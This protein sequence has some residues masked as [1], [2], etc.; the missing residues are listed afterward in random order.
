MTL[1]ELKEFAEEQAEDTVWAICSWL[2]EMGL[3][4]DVGDAQFM[5]ALGV[6]RSVYG[7]KLTDRSR[8]FYVTE[9]E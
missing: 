9:Y 1:S 3:P 4:K 5:A 8:T 7:E 2:D 6:V